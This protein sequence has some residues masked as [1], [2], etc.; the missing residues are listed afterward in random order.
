MGFKPLNSLQKVEF[1]S[2]CNNQTIIIRSNPYEVYKENVTLNVTEECKVYDTKAQGAESR[3]AT[4][5]TRIY[6]FAVHSSSTGLATRSACRIAHSGCLLCRPKSSPLHLAPA[7]T[8]SIKCAAQTLQC[9]FKYL[10]RSHPYRKF[11]QKSVS[12]Y[13]SLWT[14]GRL[15][16]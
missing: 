16:A 4:A 15:S 12:R 5:S 2:L 1:P 11:Q 7:C 10:L 14:P 3:T 13:I 9:V 6:V 8:I